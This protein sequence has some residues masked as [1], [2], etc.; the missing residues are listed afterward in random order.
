MHVIKRDGNRQPVRFD[1][2]TS[3]IDKLCQGLD[4]NYVD[5]GLIAQKV[6]A[7]VHNDVRTSQ[8]DDLACETA[9]YMTT[10]HPDYGKLAARLAVSNLHKSTEPSF[11]KTVEQLH[12]YVDPNSGEPAPLISDETLEIATEF[13]KELDEAIKHE[14]DYEYDFFGFRTLERSYL[15]RMDGAVIERPQHMLMRVA[16]GIHK[17]DMRAV[18]ETYNLMSSK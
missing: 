16:I 6:V 1:K 14:N 8:L 18:L 10:Q 13:A 17:R 4:R 12:S 5:V 15:L 3:R 9:A 2:I 7:G 11:A